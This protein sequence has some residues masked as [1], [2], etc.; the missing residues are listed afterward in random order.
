[1]S[2]GGRWYLSRSTG[3]TSNGVL[4]VTKPTTSARGVLEIES[5]HRAGVGV[6]DLSHWPKADGSPG[7]LWTV[8]E[9]PGKRLVYAC[10][11]SSLSDG[12]RATEVCG[13]W[14]NPPR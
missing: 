11:I 9:W 10:D 4:Y 3:K 12:A 7:Q 2:Y 8:T 14:S 5:A 6:E 1:V 13:P